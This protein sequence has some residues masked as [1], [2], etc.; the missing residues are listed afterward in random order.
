MLEP[1]SFDAYKNAAAPMIVMLG[2]LELNMEVPDAGMGTVG[3]DDY[4]RVSRKNKDANGVLAA[5]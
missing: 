2:H 4:R 3:S 1:G 5:M